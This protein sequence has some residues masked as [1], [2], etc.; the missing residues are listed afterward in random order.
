[1]LIRSTRYKKVT[2]NN[3]HMRKERA[4]QL[5]HLLGISAVSVS[6]PLN[7]PTHPNHHVVPA[8]A[9]QIPKPFP[10]QHVLQV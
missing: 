5:L 3:S 4:N 9:I 6:R 8:S 1:M 10:S 2:F 7:S